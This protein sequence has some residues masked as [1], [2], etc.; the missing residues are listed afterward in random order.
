MGAHP[1]NHIEIKSRANLQPAHIDI[2]LKHRDRV[3]LALIVPFCIVRAGYQVESVSRSVNFGEGK[4]H[5][6]SIDED[7]LGHD[8]IV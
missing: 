5:F 1:L 8:Y 3:Q 7:G 6:L 2:D 4:V